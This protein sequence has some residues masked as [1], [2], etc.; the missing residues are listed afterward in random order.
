MNYSR[1]N[2]ARARAPLLHPATR[3]S[4]ESK[5]NVYSHKQPPTTTSRSDFTISCWRKWTYPYRNQI[6][7]N[8]PSRLSQ[9][10]LFFSKSCAPKSSSIV[11]Y[12]CRRRRTTH[13]HNSLSQLQACYSGKWIAF[14]ISPKQR[15]FCNSLIRQY[16][17]TVLRQKEEWVSSN[18]GERLRSKLLNNWTTSQK[19]SQALQKWAGE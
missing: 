11:S 12:L 18:K 5:G 17:P 14:P 4:K 3:R 16:V 1:W 7:K 10:P 9:A 8:L 6:L 19:S 13:P 2:S 15:E